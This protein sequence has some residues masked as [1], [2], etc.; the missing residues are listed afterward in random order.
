[1]SA[2]LQIF[3]E[4]GEEK[5]GV[6]HGAQNSECTRVWVFEDFKAFFGVAVGA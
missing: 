4:N 2:L 3:K 5:Q 6:K 1:M